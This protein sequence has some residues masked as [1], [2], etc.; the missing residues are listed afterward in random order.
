MI[1]WWDC[2]DGYVGL[3]KDV[4]NWPWCC[5]FHCSLIIITILWHINTSHSLRSKRVIRPFTYSVSQSSFLGIGLG[6]PFEWNFMNGYGYGYNSLCFFIW[7]TLCN[8]RH[9]RC[10]LVF[11]C[12]PRPRPRQRL[13]HLIIMGLSSISPSTSVVAVADTDTIAIAIIVIVY[14]LSYHQLNLHCIHRHIK[15]KHTHTHRH[16]HTQIHEYSLHVRFGIWRAVIKN[17]G[18]ITHYIMR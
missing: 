10:P 2:V 1:A 12:F 17:G 14:I 18:K 16:T 5:Y 4:I 9:Y 7:A 13:S 6:Y 3:R 11:V 15:H 8:Q